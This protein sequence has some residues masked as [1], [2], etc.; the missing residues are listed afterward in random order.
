MPDFGVWRLTASCPTERCT[1]GENRREFI[2][3]TPVFRDG[4][5]PDAERLSMLMTLTAYQVRSVGATIWEILTVRPTVLDD[6]GDLAIKPKE[7][8][9]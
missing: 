1:G 4:G 2:S 9:K 3:S 7:K 6:D 5:A 8:T